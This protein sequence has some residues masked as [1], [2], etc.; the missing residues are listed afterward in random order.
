M[1]VINTAEGTVNLADVTGT[2]AIA[3]GGTGA[4]EAAQAL[5][6]LGGQPKA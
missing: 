4:T 2:L 1:E 3:N 6:N 5:E